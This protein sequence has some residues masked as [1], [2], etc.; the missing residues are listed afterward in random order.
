MVHH[1]MNTIVVVMVIVG[2]FTLHLN[3]LSVLFTAKA[4]WPTSCLYSVVN[5]LSD[6]GSVG[7]PLHCVF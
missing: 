4:L 2:G 6:S 7:G 3:S 5:L 1:D